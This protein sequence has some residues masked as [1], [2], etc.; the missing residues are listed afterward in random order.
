MTS[1]FSAPIELNMNWDERSTESKVMLTSEVP[2]RSVEKRPSVSIMSSRNYSF[3][4]IGLVHIQKPRV[5]GFTVLPV[6]NESILIS[7]EVIEYRYYNTC[8]RVN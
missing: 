1:S 6:E 5:Q 8:Q 2:D 3:L 4:L 7:L